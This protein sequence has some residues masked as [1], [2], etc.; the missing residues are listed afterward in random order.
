MD[1]SITHNT[2]SDFTLRHICGSVGRVSGGALATNLPEHYHSGWGKHVYL[3][4]R[5]CVWMNKVKQD[6]IW[7]PCRYNT[8]IRYNL[9]HSQTHLGAIRCRSG[10]GKLFSRLI[11]SDWKNS[12][13]CSSRP[14]AALRSNQRV[15]LMV[16]LTLGQTKGPLPASFIKPCKQWTL[17]PGPSWG[18]ID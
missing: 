17:W 4:Q 2:N 11:Q 7:H 10:T 13:E 9:I 5:W 15:Y 8:S 1:E 18:E 3:W 6:S 12:C 14:P 16:N